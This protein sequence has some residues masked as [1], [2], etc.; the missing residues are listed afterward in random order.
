[1]DKKCSKCK[2]IKI[3]SDFY[4]ENKNGNKYHYKCKK[5]DRKD[6]IKY[7]SANKEKILINRRNNSRMPTGHYHSIKS[8][9]KKR[10]LSICSKKDFLNW[11]E[12]ID[13]TSCHYCKRKLEEVIKDNVSNAKRMTVDRMNNKKGYDIGNMIICCALCN[14]IKGAFFTYEEMMKIGE[15]IIARR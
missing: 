3:I 13:I 14:T 7:F 4:K 5:C 9:A 6:W 1:M 15:I 2:E 12:S 10:N 11:Y 8:S